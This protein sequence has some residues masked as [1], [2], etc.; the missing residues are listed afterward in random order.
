MGITNN[1]VRDP[2]T[3]EAVNAEELRTITGQTSFQAPARGV[4]GKVN[5]AL[6]Y[7]LGTG[8]TEN[9]LRAERGLEPRLSHFGTTHSYSVAVAKGETLEQLLGRYFMSDNSAIPAE[10]MAVIRAAFIE[11][12]ST[13]EDPKAIMP[14]DYTLLFPHGD[15]I[16][17]RLSLI[18][19]KPD[20]GERAKKLRVRGSK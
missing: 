14:V 20:L 17:T 18:L 8:I 12:N 11:F 6:D 5:W 10:M 3:G 7:N 16:A 15:Y 9:Q 2:G 19:H 13:F 4:S 1:L